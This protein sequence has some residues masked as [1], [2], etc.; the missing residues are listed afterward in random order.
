[1]L[2]GPTVKQGQHMRF[3][4]KNS[5]NSLF[6]TRPHLPTKSEFTKSITKTYTVIWENNSVL[7]LSRYGF[8]IPSCHAYEIKSHE[9][10]QSV[11]QTRDISNTFSY[12]RF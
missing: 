3:S 12:G 7:I 11:Y 1:M 2:R 5:V 10:E 4:P 6:V 9:F 8:P